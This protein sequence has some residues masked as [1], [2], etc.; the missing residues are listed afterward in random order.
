ME[1]R[2]GCLEDAAD[3]LEIYRPLVLDTV[4]SFEE[5]LPSVEQFGERMERAL[6]RY[7]WLVAEIESRPAG[8]AYATQFRSRSAYRFAVETTIYIDSQF[9][10]RGLGRRLYEALFGELSKRDFRQAFAGITLP[11]DP[12]IALHRSVGFVPVG[13]LR[14][15]GYK[16]EQWHDVSWWQRSI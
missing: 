10:G 9:H 4:I 8:Y 16:F 3:L 13:T 5:T 6:D 1:I 7:V 15:V 2:S 12:S 11:N 14:R